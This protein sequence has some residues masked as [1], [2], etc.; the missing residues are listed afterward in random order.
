MLVALLTVAPFPAGRAAMWSAQTVTGP[1]KRLVTGLASDPTGMLWGAITGRSFGRGTVPAAADPALAEDDARLASVEDRRRLLLR[2]L[3]DGKIAGGAG[4]DALVAE[5]ESVIA[6]GESRGSST[7]SV[8]ARFQEPET[9]PAAGLV[10][11]TTGRLIFA[12]TPSLWRISPADGTAQAII[13]GLGVRSGNAGPGVLSPI[14]LPNGDLAFLTSSRGA[15]PESPDSGRLGLIDTPAL[16]RCSPDGSHLQVL[17]ANLQN[18]SAVCADPIGRIW[19]AEVT[20][21]Q[22]SRLHCLHQGSTLTE[23]PI[24]IPGVITC[25]LPDPADPVSHDTVSLLAGFGPGTESGI[26]R[27]IATRSPQGWQLATSETLWNGGSTTAITIT[28]DGSAFWTDWGSSFSANAPC[29]ILKAMA[30]PDTLVP[31]WASGSVF[32]RD[33]PLRLSDAQLAERLRSIHPPLRAM[34]AREINRRASPEL[35]ASCHSIA[36]DPELPPAARLNALHCLANLAASHPALATEFLACASLPDATLR[37][38]AALRLPECEPGMASPVALRLLSD[39]APAVAAAALLAATELDPVSTASHVL[40]R[41]PE[42]IPA[43]HSLKAALTAC[44]ARCLPPEE[45]ADRI[46][47]ETPAEL[48]AIIFQSLRLARHPAAADALLD[49]DPAMATEAAIQLYDDVFLPAWPAIAAL[50]D[51]CGT[52]PAFSNP[53]LLA[54]ILAAA[55]RTGTPAAAQTVRRLLELPE[56][57]LPAAS[58]ALALETLASWHQPPELDPIHKRFLPPIPRDQ[59]T[60]RPALRAILPQLFSGS[61][62]AR[63]RELSRS[64]APP[65]AER[66]T[67]HALDSSQPESTRLRALRLLGEASPSL[68]AQ[69]SWQLLRPTEPPALPLPNATELP[70]APPPPRSPPPAALLAEARR[71]TLQQSPGSLPSQLASSLESGTVPELQTVLR[72]LNRYQGNDSEQ[73]WGLVV[74]RWIL[75]QPD[76]ACHVEILEALTSRD[77]EPRS[78]WRRWLEQWDASL[79]SNFDPLA[80]WRMTQAGGDPALG[81]IIFESHPSAQCLSCHQ[82]NAR[83]GS[84]GPEI[85]GLAS[86]LS[87]S[88]ILEAL[89]SPSLKCQPNFARHSITLTDG[90][91]RSGHINRRN[92][93]ETMLDTGSRFLAIPGAAIAS[94]SE[95]ASPMPSVATILTPR[96]IRDLMAWLTSLK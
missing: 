71:L 88:A 33:D 34:A 50:A 47:S 11:E 90:S 78:R 77:H 21:P 41:L 40:A 26:K 49:P 22:S 2:W 1:D 60:A 7:R 3:A 89:I 10:S 95:P 64:T 74:S 86:R 66:L 48:R 92:A 28:P 65:T 51:R 39:P 35:A 43:D 46:R 16:L 24:V 54:R 75:G 55:Q 4:P 91:I 83:G 84:T 27:I 53:T 94:V 79:R 56:P 70:A 14:T 57:I 82:I 12:C 36:A 73:L 31:A 85:D 20:G 8:S 61:L 44:L 13:S 76:P 52:A 69:T 18:P 23:N 29:R 37:E 6:I 19:L 38:A 67:S 25:V 58:R 87:P 80:R 45:L 96:E 17:A 63:A 62:A 30:L 81:R 15:R 5:S 32:L 72:A 59:D 42:P 9:G 93:T 68:A